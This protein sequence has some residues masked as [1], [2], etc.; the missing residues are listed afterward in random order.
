MVILGI[1]V[2]GLGDLVSFK[3]DS[4]CFVVDSGGD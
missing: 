1:I 3:F 4:F 2:F